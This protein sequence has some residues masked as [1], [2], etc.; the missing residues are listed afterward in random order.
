VA[1]AST[2]VKVNPLPEYAITPASRDTLVCKGSSVRLSVQTGTGISY[3]WSDGNSQIG[4]NIKHVDVSPAVSQYYYV[5]IS[6]NKQC[7]VR[8][9]I[10]VEVLSLPVI[11][12]YG[13]EDICLG[14][15]IKLEVDG[16]GNGALRYEWNTKPTT[17]GGSI[18]V[19]PV[20]SG[21][22]SVK[23]IDEYGCVSTVTSDTI[24]VN[25]L[26]K[27]LISGDADIC[28][29]K[30][31]TLAVVAEASYV[32]YL[33]NDGSEE[34]QIIVNPEQETPYTVTVTDNKGCTGTASTTVKVNPL[35]EYTLSADTTVCNGNAVKLKVAAEGIG[36]G[37]KWSTESVNNLISVTPAVSQYYYVEISNSK[38]CSVRDSVWVE[39]L[40]LPNIEIFG[41]T[42]ICF[43]DSIVLEADGNGNGALRYEWNTKPT[44]TGGSITVAPVKS[45]I[46]SVK[47]IDEYGCVSIKESDTVTVHPL[48][49]PAISGKPEICFGESLTLTATGGVIYDWGDDD[50]TMIDNIGVS[51]QNDTVYTVEVTDIHGCMAKA[52][53]AVKVNPLPVIVTSPDTSICRGN[54]VKLDA[55]AAGAG[56]TYKWSTESR[57][58][59]ITVVP[60]ASQYYFVEA[61]DIRQCVAKDSIR[62]EVLAL[63]E[64]DITGEG[65]ICLGDTVELTA[66]GASTYEWNTKETGASIMIH[67]LKPTSYTVKGFDDYGCSSTVSFDV[68][69]KQLPVPVISG[70]T[71]ICY[72]DSDTLTASGGVSYDWAN[73][74]ADFN[75]AVVSPVTDAEYSVIVTGSN[76]CSASASIKIKVHSLPILEPIADTMI[77]LGESVR[78]N[79]V[80]AGTGLTYRWST[81]QEARGIEVT[82]P[83]TQSLW[84]EI[85]DFRKCS[86]REDVLIEVLSL[87]VLDIIGPRNV[88]VG[89]ELTLTAVGAER[90]IW[91]S[92]FEGDTYTTAPTGSAT[93]QLTGTDEY[94]CV[95]SASVDITVHS[96]PNVAVEIDPKVISLKY[97]E[98]QFKAL[99]GNETMDTY[100]DFGDAE[101]SMQPSIKH[102][103]YIRKDDSLYEAVFIVTDQNGCTDTLR[104]TIYV[105]PFI[106]TAFTPNGDGIND[107]FM[108]DCAACDI[109]RI[110][111]RL[112]VK[113][114]EGS[115]GWDG[116]YNGKYVDNDTYFYVIT[117]KYNILGSDSRKGY[118]TVG[119][120][121]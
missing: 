3:K 66:L 55:Q 121:N 86:A 103:Y 40:N 91:S 93:Y 43:G 80:G 110:F 117:F 38:Q 71:E 45:G 72:G 119:R 64:I 48:P 114:Y 44:T 2:T 27:P 33:W 101:W 77:C 111:D 35:P 7:S 42:D 15:S 34:S 105:E 31:A 36:I 68:D 8:D 115:K 112:G 118:I 92:G 14:E 99:T 81:G 106:P 78:L 84:V 22:Y 73:T 60:D 24:I 79:A 74:L 20:K 57:V 9:S 62:V 67:P 47:G 116:K 102:R 53:T 89:D 30:S 16:S 109:I 98:V 29:G 12:I 41:E 46:Y 70:A 65:E 10:W 76:G 90:Y 88:C 85:T 95:S 4:G 18:T 120:K 58:N 107:V 108:D 25:P 54:S 100:W 21:T 26:P 32:S 39:V 5:E 56:I 97:P 63:P 96:R 17:T 69:I 19:A 113:M 28:F 37:Y 104:Q 6:N 87:P 49:H 83:E 51:P 50:F 59:T 61:T 52:S 75:I 82:P 1:T 23:G 11:D 13:E 94:G